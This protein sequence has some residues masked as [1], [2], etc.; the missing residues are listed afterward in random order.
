VH[1]NAEY[2][3]GV[4]LKLGYAQGGVKLGQRNKANITATCVCASPKA[5][6]VRRDALGFEILCDP[7][8]E[9]THGYEQLPTLEV[10]VTAKPNR[11][12][13]GNNGFGC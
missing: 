7:A 11:Q 9:S 2:V 8:A 10:D 6:A 5:V 3:E 1:V 13:C 4:H 12:T